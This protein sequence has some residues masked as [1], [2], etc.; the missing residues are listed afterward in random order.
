M[1]TFLYHYLHVSKITVY[2]QFVNFSYDRHESHGHA[3]IR[4]TLQSIGLLEPIE[5]IMRSHLDYENV[6]QIEGYHFWWMVLFYLNILSPVSICVSELVVPML[7]CVGECSIVGSH[8]WD[9]NWCPHTTA[10]SL[11][12]LNNKA[13]L[14]FVFETTSFD[15]SCH[16]ILFFVPHLYLLVYHLR[17]PWGSSCSVCI[18]RTS[19]M[20]YCISCPRP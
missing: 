6:F 8:D 7:C 10:S 20:M 13:L 2:K 1:V 15:L 16:H 19:A 11:M 14:P 4:F 3:K 9:W 5:K 17:E 18:P 12:A